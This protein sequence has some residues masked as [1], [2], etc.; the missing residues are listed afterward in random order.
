LT[1]SPAFEDIGEEVQAKCL[2]IVSKFKA[3]TLTRSSAI[4]E[5]F[6]AIPHSSRTPSLRPSALISFD[7]TRSRDVGQT[8]LPCKQSRFNCP[9]ES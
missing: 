8:L 5:L 7:L 9:R 3:E 4:L 2:E 6:E 1:R